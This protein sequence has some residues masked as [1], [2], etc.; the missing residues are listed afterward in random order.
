MVSFWEDGNY[1]KYMVCFFL[2]NEGLV[3]Y[4]VWGGFIFKRMRFVG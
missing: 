1:L 4:N 3:D 2:G